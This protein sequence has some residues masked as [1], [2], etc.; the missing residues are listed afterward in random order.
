[1]T[2]HRNL[3]NLS[4]KELFGFFAWNILYPKLIQKRKAVV[5]VIWEEFTDCEQRN[6]V[7]TRSS[8]EHMLDRILD[9]KFFPKVTVE[10]NR[11]SEEIEIHTI[12]NYPQNLRLRNLALEM[13]DTEK[14]FSRLIPE[15]YHDMMTIENVE[16][17]PYYQLIQ[18]K[19]E[20]L[21]NG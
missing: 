5:S 1:M 20:E 6:Y 16:E 15:V 21:S 14:E 9:L 11:A 19:W 18:S 3:S 17:L 7:S 8:G 10:N 2:Y 12:M 13:Y 4:R